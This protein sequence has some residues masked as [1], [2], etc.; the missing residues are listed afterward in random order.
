RESCIHTVARRVARYYPYLGCEYAIEQLP[1]G[2]LLDAALRTTIDEWTE[3]DPEMALAWAESRQTVHR[4]DHA[5]S[6]I[7]MTLV[8]EDD[9]GNAAA[10]ATMM[11][12]GE[13]RD[14]VLRNAIEEWGDSDPDIAAEWAAELEDGAIRTIVMETLAEYM[15]PDSDDEPEPEPDVEE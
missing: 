15:E 13:Q 6:V 3:N 5:F 11:T 9:P 1:E 2:R 7:A 10:V 14:S 12:P 4:R 8:D